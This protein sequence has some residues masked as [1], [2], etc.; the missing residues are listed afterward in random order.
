MTLRS[1]DRGSVI[2]HGQ[3]YLDIVKRMS[4]A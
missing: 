1:K 2:M 3:K 4:A